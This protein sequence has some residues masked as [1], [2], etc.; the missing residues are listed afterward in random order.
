LRSPP[1][2]SERLRRVV[3]TGQVPSVLKEV[4]KS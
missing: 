2:A 4:K 1:R 3:R